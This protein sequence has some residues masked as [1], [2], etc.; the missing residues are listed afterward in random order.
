MPA[1]IVPGSHIV[2]SVVEMEFGGRRV[3]ALV[4]T[5]TELSMRGGNGGL[6][7][8][9]DEACH[10]KPAVLAPA[11]GH[12]FGSVAARRVGGESSQGCCLPSVVSAFVVHLLTSV[13]SLFSW[14]FKGRKSAPTLVGS[15]PGPS[16]GK[17]TCQ[18]SDPV[19]GGAPTLET[20]DKLASFRAGKSSNRGG[21]ALVVGSGSVGA[22][23]RCRLSAVEPDLMKGGSPPIRR[24]G[25]NALL[26]VGVPVTS[27]R[28]GPN[29]LPPVLRA[30]WRRQRRRRRRRPP[31]GLND[32]SA[33]KVLNHNNLRPCQALDAAGNQCS[34]GPAVGRTLNSEPGQ[35]QGG[36]PT[37]GGSDGLP[38]PL[39]GAWLC[40]APGPAPLGAVGRPGATEEGPE[41]AYGPPTPVF[42][43]YGRLSRPVAP[44]SNG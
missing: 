38:D 22:E 26:R 32:N 13:L 28:A 35:V 6:R 9:G 37:P 44:F 7:S 42:T 4:D 19:Q 2:A 8:T 39:V 25:S 30:R 43:R 41:V 5:G 20:T 10:D 16:A 36:A 17:G 18:G 29:Q 40:S 34:P 31:R 1:G 15:A 3:W 33:E 27:S 14:V 21:A 11:L 12:W 23:T 24:L